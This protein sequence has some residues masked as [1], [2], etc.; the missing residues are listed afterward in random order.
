MV[1]ADPK[2]SIL[3]PLVNDGITIEAGSWLVEGIGE[4]FIPSIADFS[5]VKK[6]YTVTDGESFEIARTL[7]RK[8]G[9][10]A[11]SSTGVLVHAAIQYA[12]EQTDPK[13]IVTFACDSG[14]K[15]LSRM[16]NDYW[17]I[18]TGSW[19]RRSRPVRPI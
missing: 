9:I 8:E 16:F 5:M 4:D 18:D 10:L 15:Y 11:G 3:A 1:L 6:G 7:L 19:G 2:G 14:N 17:L 12:H 13:N